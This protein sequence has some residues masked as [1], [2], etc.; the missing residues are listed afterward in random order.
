MKVLCNVMYAK[1]GGGLTYALNQVGALAAQPDV[2]VHVLV[3]PWNIEAFR[4]L[5]GLP[6]TSVHPIDVPNVPARFAWEQL[7]LPRW[8]RRRS[9][10]LILNSG[11]FAPL[12]CATPNA[13]VLQ[14]PNFVG[15]GRA[16]SASRGR[17]Y[18]AKVRLSFEGMRRS[19]VVISVSNVL[20]EEIRSEPRLRSVDVVTVRTADPA[21]TPE[22]ASR[23]EVEAV[24]GTEPYV[25]SVANDY[26]HKRLDDLGELAA[27]AASVPGVPD[28]VV[29]AGDIPEKRR[30]DIE[31]RAGSACDRLQFLGAVSDRAL[32][33][34]LYR[35]AF[36]AVSTSEMESWGLTL[37]E[38]GMHGCP[39]IATDLPAHRE[40]A[41]DH[42]RYVAPGDVQGML[43]RLADLVGEPRPEPWGMDRSW[44][45]HGR[46]LAGVLRRV[47]GVTG[48]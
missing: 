5:P 36:A 31:A 43:D 45:E 22:V 41:G 46:E 10:D 16:R 32:V 34:G 48:R 2:Q 39:V 44:D 8:A 23:S 21:P 3:S 13:M 11:N 14:N 37:P 17:G 19:D 25:L 7:V 20:A 33:A 4:S 26:P 40:V 24:V 6:S 42:A 29:F 30:S 12:V 18:R 38:A 35:Q 1:V 28:R 15:E 9:F 47:A 27:R